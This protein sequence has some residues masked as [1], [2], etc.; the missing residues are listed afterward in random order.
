MPEFAESG[1]QKGDAVV[2]VDAE[3]PVFTAT[4]LIAMHDR[5]LD[6]SGACGIYWQRKPAFIPLGAGEKIGFQRFS[7]NFCCQHLE[8][9]CQKASPFLEISQE[10]ID[11]LV[12]YL[13]KTGLAET[14]LEEKNPLLLSLETKEKTEKKWI[15]LQYQ[16]EIWRKLSSQWYENFKIWLKSWRDSEQAKIIKK[17]TGKHRIHLLFVGRPFH[18]RWIRER[19]GD[20]LHHY[21][22]FY[23]DTKYHI[24]EQ[25]KRLVDRGLLEFLNREKQGLP[26]YEDWLPDLYLEV[27]EKGIPKHIQIFE[28]RS[29]Q[30]GQEIVYNVQ[31]VMELT[32]N[33]PDYRIPLIRDKQGRYPISYE[34]KLEHPSF[35]WSHSIYVKMQ[36][37]YKY[38][39]DSYR[40]LVKP[41]QV[42]SAPFQEIEFQ[43]G[44]KI[45][46]NKESLKNIP[47][48]FPQVQVWEGCELKRCLDWFL[49]AEKNLED[50]VAN[51]NDYARRLK[52]PAFINYYYSPHNQIKRLL[53]NIRNLIEKKLLPCCLVLWQP[54]KDSFIRTPEFDRA[55]E[56]AI[57]LLTQ[58]AKLYLKDETLQETTD[59]LNDFSWET[60]SFL[61]GDA[62]I[63]FL[64]YLE[65]NIRQGNNEY[66]MSLWLG[67][68]LGNGKNNRR[69]LF[70]F[71]LKEIEQRFEH[72]RN[73]PQQKKKYS[74]L[75]RG[76]ATALWR[77]QELVHSLE[78]VSS[79]PKFLEILEYDYRGIIKTLKKTEPDNQK[80][81][82][83]QS[84]NF[85]NLNEILMALLRL[86][87][88][89][90]ELH[91]G[92]SRMLKISQYLREIDVLLLKFGQECK[93]CFRFEW[94]GQKKP[95][96]MS[97]LV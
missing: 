10:Q 61:R 63:D 88:Q 27:L 17:Y 22:D 30:P 9:L 96:G 41:V 62:P 81:I 12:A 95:E 54:D 87:S 53:D 31:D 55:L 64:D 66:Q 42:A 84:R 7:K 58:L 70:Q 28:S 91:A 39:L 40:L 26:S 23:Q 20:Y 43:W 36:V 75:L 73:S 85:R 56:K 76:L 50:H 16:E 11:K 18:N 29:A 4:C 92:N 19:V 45:F 77:N 90:I 68:V 89:E 72:N 97:E 14:F 6:D 34:A 25:A 2:V 48:Q 44:R 60:L 82:V 35:P 86:R 94:E 24:P 47:P 33:Q 46:Q 83:N 59:S 21:L 37:A 69:N 79:I 5:R 93:S 71:L 57:R 65:F 3:A 38:G 15:K 13:E 8:N 74:Y 1:V 49:E 51:L 52:E 32:A 78:E 80:L 67:R